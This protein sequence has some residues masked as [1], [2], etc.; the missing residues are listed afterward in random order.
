MLTG[1]FEVIRHGSRE[2]RDYFLFIPTMRAAKPRPLLVMLHGCQQRAVD[3]AASTGMNELA[4]RQR[5][6]TLYPEQS[7]T[8]N[9][10]RCWNW[11]LP[12]QAAGEGEAAAIATLIG[13]IASRYPVDR[14]RIY[15]AGLS[16]GGALTAQLAMR[17]GVLFAACAVIA[18]LMHRA[19][20]SP[21]E[22]LQA[23][24]S[25]SRRSPT[26]IVEE[27][28][29]DPKDTL[30]FV[31]A[32]ILSGDRDTTVHPGNAEKLVAQFRRVAEL[33]STPSA[34][35]DL[36]HSRVLHPAGGRRY[37]QDDYAQHGRVL[38]RSISVEGLGHAWSGGDAAYPF[39]E[40]D[41]PKAS[42]LVWEFV[43]GF[44]RRHGGA[45]QKRPRW[46]RLLNL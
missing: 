45:A 16:A 36:V 19:A 18:G 34:A 21:A 3:F 39:N 46:K 31:P 23:M 35:L 2:A 38:L 7:L 5:F 13:A 37:R 29:R 1:K 20:D 25:G 6:L 17:H 27:L 14:S 41:A 8:A 22:A 24:R 42:A 12:E 40:A 15:V 33:S 32:L 26:G 28:A 10:F 30:S 43:S 11:F 9:A 4:Q 44:E